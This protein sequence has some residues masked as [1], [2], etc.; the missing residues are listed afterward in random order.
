MN[1]TTRSAP[2]DIGRDKQR[3]AAPGRAADNDRANNAAKDLAYSL[4]T[5]T[6]IGESKRRM[7][8]CDRGRHGEDSAIAARMSGVRARGKGGLA[9]GQSRAA[10]EN[11]NNAADEQAEPLWNAANSGCQADEERSA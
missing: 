4:R 6:Q 11:G 1:R 9:D 3:H 8:A 7:T 2:I 5:A 10:R